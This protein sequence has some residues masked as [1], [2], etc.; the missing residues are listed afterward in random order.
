MFW[1]GERWIDERAPAPAPRPTRRRGRDWLATGIMIVGIA[2]LAVPFI[3]LSGTSGATF[4]FAFTF[5]GTG[6][7]WVGTLDPDLGKANVSVAGEGVD[8]FIVCSAKPSNVDPT[9]G[10]P[11]D[12]TPATAGPTPA[13]TLTPTPAP[14]AAATSISTPTPTPAPTP[15]ST[16]APTPTLT[17]APT[18]TAT[19][20]PTPT[21]TAVFWEGFCCGAITA[22]LVLARVAPGRHPR[23]AQKRLRRL[24][25]ALIA[26]LV[27]LGSG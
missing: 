16:P 15:A 14:S 18:P 13:P 21:P 3:A 22:V 27:R 8:A 17:P 5:T 20:A 4:T 11:A 9:P 2:A 24:A 1:D 26:L 12:P 25:R 10:P 7:S 23:K 6:V 19:P